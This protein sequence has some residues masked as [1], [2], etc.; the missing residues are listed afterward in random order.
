MARHDPRTGS[1]DPKLAHRLF[2]LVETHQGYA[3]I[4]DGIEVLSRKE[5]I[6]LAQGSL[7]WSRQVVRDLE[8]F[9]KESGS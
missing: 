3:F 4:S 6:W 5:I 9:L 2:G 8:K 7:K 1:P